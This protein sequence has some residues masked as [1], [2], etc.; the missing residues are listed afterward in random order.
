MALHCLDIAG[1]LRL[2]G[3]LVAEERRI[4]V[5]KPTLELRISRHKALVT[6]SSR[7]PQRQVNVV[8]GGMKTPRI[9]VAVSVS[10]VHGL[11]NIARAVE[12]S[13]RDEIIRIELVL[14]PQKSEAIAAGIIRQQRETRAPA[15]LM[16]AIADRAHPVGAVVLLNWVWR[17]ADCERD[18]YSRRP[19]RPARVEKHP[20][21]VLRQR[22]GIVRPLLDR[23]RRNGSLQIVAVVVAEVPGTP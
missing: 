11:I 4:P 7:P 15:D 3:V 19:H 13:I 21:D 2:R 17:N 16:T 8:H 5:G 14:S 10:S 1:F 22:P 12:K 18:L 9:P 6:R 23:R 20:G